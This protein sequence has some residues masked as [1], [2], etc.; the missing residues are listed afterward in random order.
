MS[1]SQPLPSCAQVAQA[2][3]KSLPQSLDSAPNLRNPGS[4][5]LSP[6]PAVPQ[7]AQAAAKAPAA[8][9]GLGQYL[10]LLP[11]IQA[12]AEFERLLGSAANATCAAGLRTFTAALLA[13]HSARLAA[14]LNASAGL[15]PAR[16][17]INSQSDFLGRLSKVP[18]H[19]PIPCAAG[20]GLLPVRAQGA[21]RRRVAA[22]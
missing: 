1:P 13:P 12:L 9:E 10:L 4:A 20:P 22:S 15:R 17:A 18:T 3:A 8:A 6:F 21:W 14:E 7:V 19:K 5:R 2:A 11:V 16:A